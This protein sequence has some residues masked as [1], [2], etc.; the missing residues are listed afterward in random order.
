[1]S[2]RS[3]AHA[4]FGDAVRAIRKQGG[5]SQ[6]SLALKSGMDRTY[7]SGIECGTRNPSLANVFKLAAALEVSPAEL[8]ARAQ[9]VPGDSAD[10][11]R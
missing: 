8:F 9:D 7:L 4:A 10:G 11:S 3:P 2:I 1:M 6:E 5:V